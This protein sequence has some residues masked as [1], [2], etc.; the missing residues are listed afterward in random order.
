MKSTL[1][2]VTVC[3][4]LTC[5]AQT[6]Q[7]AI[8]KTENEN[9]EKATAEFRTLLSKDAAKGDVY[10]HA[11]ENYFKSGEIDSAR[12][13]FQKG[14]EVN[15]TYPL[16]YVGLGKLLLNENKI[17]EAKTQFF[18]ATTLGGGKNADVAR[19]IAEAW[20]ATDNKD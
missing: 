2:I 13:Y 6:L 14:T 9:F 4:A 3:A 20:L 11:G 1:I 19:E 12:K 10:F 5:S 16:N 8:T 18:K 15:A 17:A 7:D